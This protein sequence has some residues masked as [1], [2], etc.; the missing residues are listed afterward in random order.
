MKT[1]TKYIIKTFVLLC[2]TCLLSSC[3]KNDTES[4]ELYFQENSKAAIPTYDSY[5]AIQS[6]IKEKTDNPNCQQNSR[7][8][9]IGEAADNFFDG[10]NPNSF[11]NED[12]LLAFYQKNQALLDTMID[13]NNEIAVYP[14]WHDNPYRYVANKDGMFI[15][16]NYVSRIIKNGTI[17][18]ELENIEA[19]ANATEN[20]A[21]MMDISINQSKGLPTHGVNHP[22]CKTNLEWYTNT[23]QKIAP[24]NYSSSNDRVTLKLITQFSIP[25]GEYHAH[26]YVQATSEHK[27]IWWWPEK[28]TISCSSNVTIHKYMYNDGWI[29]MPDVQSKTQNTYVLTIYVDDMPLGG[30]FKEND[31]Y[32]YW[33]YN[34]SATTSAAGTARLILNH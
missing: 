34:I 31:V 14:K 33:S 6:I 30:N 17:T 12:E 26:T 20:E 16:G 1:K 28:H 19:L 25:G 18:T 13:K 21:R 10:I 7:F 27:T 24:A 11:E 32:H 15:V 3:T 8:T 29:Q 5:E 22:G 9:S 4:T 2:T 23:I